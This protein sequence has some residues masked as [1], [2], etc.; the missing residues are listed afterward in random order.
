MRATPSG[1]PLALADGLHV[2]LKA[3]CPTCR[4]VVPVLRELEEAGT[5]VHAWFQ[6]EGDFLHGLS[7]VRDDSSLE[8]SFRLGV[9]TVPTVIRVEGGKETARTEGWVRE[10]WRTLTSLPGLGADLREWQAGC[11]SLSVLPGVAEILTARYGDPGIKSRPVEVDRFQDPVEVCYDRGWSDGLP[12]VPPT[13]ERI[14]R[15]LSGTVR[16]PGEVI[17]RMPPDLA[18]LTVE[19]VA[20]NAVLA[21][22]RPE[23]LPLLL[24]IVETALDPRFTLHGVTCTTCFSSPVIVVNGPVARRLGMNPGIG[25]LGP[26]N[27]ATATIG[28]ALNLIVRNVGGGRPGEIDRSTLGAPSKF[29]F[30][31]AEDESDPAWEPLSVAR[32]IPPGKSAVTLFQGEG[33]Q[34]VVDQRSRTPEELTR[35]LAA[36]LLAVNHT[37]LCQWGNAILVL[38]PE[39]YGIFKA[40]GWDRARITAELQAA[41]TRPGAEVVRGAGGIGEGV[42][43]ERAGDPAI[44]KFHP[45]GLLLVRAGGPAGLYSAIIS[46]WIGGRAADESQPV[47]REILA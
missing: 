5:R 24:G 19:K 6:D 11:G 33:I 1:A 10:D 20:I 13:P 34:G 46:G 4:L 7:D 15:M 3:D 22:C 29:T 37:K 31:F 17:G 26:G 38:A 25:A 18:E 42:P 41:T 35:S 27:R 43:A 9:H 16:E 28:R 44:P 40:A 45:N 21:G 2:A 30:C 12:V 32:G 8:T 14:L 23:Y 36:S 47:T 39:H